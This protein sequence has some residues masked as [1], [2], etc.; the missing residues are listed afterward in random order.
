MS[1]YLSILRRDIR[2]FVVNS[3]YR[4]FTELQ[5]NAKRKEIELDIQTRE[6]GES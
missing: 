4:T 2:E 5:A 1:R 3:S 6:E